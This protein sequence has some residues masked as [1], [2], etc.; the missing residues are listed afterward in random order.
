MLSRL[1]RRN[2]ARL[3]RSGARNN[4]VP[5]SEKLDRKSGGFQMAQ[6]QLSLPDI[7]VD[8][9]HVIHRSNNPDDSAGFFQLQVAPK[10]SVI[11]IDYS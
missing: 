7:D 11:S 9:V 4:S 6:Y 10:I 3:R 8:P 2:C 5:M 1:V